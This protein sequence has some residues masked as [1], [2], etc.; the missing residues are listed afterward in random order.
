MLLASLIGIVIMKDRTT[1]LKKKFNTEIIC[2]TKT[3]M[4]E[5]YYD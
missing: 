2:P 4:E 1:Q 3:T 5:A